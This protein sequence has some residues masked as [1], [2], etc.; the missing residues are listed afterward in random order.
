MPE[1]TLRQL[2]VR[3]PPRGFEREKGEV[4]LLALRQD[5]LEGG[6]G[7][8]KYKNIIET[9]TSVVVASRTA[10]GINRTSHLGVVPYGDGELG[11]QRK[12][13][14][15]TKAKVTEHLFGGGVGQSEV[16]VRAGKLTLPLGSVGLMAR[17]SSG[18]R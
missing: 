16:A 4:V 3:G 15:S 10:E 18:S 14:N 2:A 11:L 9:N 5:R 17:L 1:I 8:G 6:S 13:Q 12:E 7:I